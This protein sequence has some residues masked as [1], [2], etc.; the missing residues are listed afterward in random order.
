[1]GR[2]GL[3]AGK[4]HQPECPLPTVPALPDRKALQ[5]GSSRN[6]Q[7]VLKDMIGSDALD[8]QPLL[9][10]FQ[11]IS[12][13]LQEQNRKNGEVLGWPEYQ[14][15]P[16]MPNNYPESIGNALDEGGAGP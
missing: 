6:W 16:P 1:M 12:Q 2:V 13:W 14:W 5:A 3:G 4:G 7:E 15:R 9:N 10:Y 8:A 11:P